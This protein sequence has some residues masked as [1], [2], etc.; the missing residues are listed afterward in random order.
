MTP[1]FTECVWILSH[2]YYSHS[3]REQ[4]QGEG[5]S[6]KGQCCRF[7]SEIIFS[8][9]KPRQISSVTA[10]ECHL[11]LFSGVTLPVFEHYQEGGDSKNPVL[12]M[13]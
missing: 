9:N 13:F 6:K 5:Q 7:A 3:E 1:D 4:G 8:Y 11:C 12:F 10:H 2:Q